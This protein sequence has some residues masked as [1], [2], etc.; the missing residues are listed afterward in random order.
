MVWWRWG[1][2][3]VI[4]VGWV[5]VKERKEGGLRDEEGGGEETGGSRQ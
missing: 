1:V 2:D 3:G 4:E 5:W